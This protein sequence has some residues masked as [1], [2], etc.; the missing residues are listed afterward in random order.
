MEADLV[1]V[2]NRLQAVEGWFDTVS[3]SGYI[4]TSRFLYAPKVYAGQFLVDDG[5]EGSGTLDLATHYHTINVDS[6]GKLYLG[7]PTSNQQH[8]DITSVVTPVFGA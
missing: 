6:D 3:A 8:T 7:G 4:R 2:S 5:M 1:T